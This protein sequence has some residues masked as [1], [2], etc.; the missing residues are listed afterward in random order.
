MGRIVFDTNVCSLIANSPNKIAVMGHLRT[1]Y[2]VAASANTVYE[3]L[4][5]LCRSTSGQYFERDQER[6]KVAFGYGSL[7]S[8]KFLD[9]GLAFALAYGPQ[10][11]TAETGMGARIFRGYTKLVLKARSLEELR[12]KGVRW[13]GSK[14]RILKCDVIEADFDNAKLFYRTDV[15][16]PLPDRTRWAKDLAAVVKVNLTDGQAATFSNSLD[17]LYAYEQW[18]RAAVSGT[19]NPEKNVNDRMD[20]HQLFY[21][22]D[23]SIEFITSEE[24]IRKRIGASQQ[25]YRVVLLNDFLSRE[26]LVL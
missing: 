24:K 18:L 16:S 8:A 20:M 12:V 17:G 21:L 3:L 7:T 25:S 11:T 23:P 10:I 13:F 2:K 5:G 15:R 1:R 22:A 9:H 19:F 6:F 4:L 14:G 26:G